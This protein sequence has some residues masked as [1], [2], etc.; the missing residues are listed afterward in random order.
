MYQFA[1]LTRWRMPGVFSC[2]R[3]LWIKPM[4]MFIDRFLSERYFISLGCVS[5]SEITVLYCKVYIREC[6]T[7]FQSGC[8]IFSS[9]R[10][11]MN[12]PLLC[13]L[14]SSCCSLGCCLVGWLVLLV[15]FCFF[16]HS[17]LLAILISLCY[18]FHLQFSNN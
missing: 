7:L 13:I 17:Y 6:Q 1:N 16:N 3:D 11:C 5:G 18:F 15:F 10:Q 2:L 4:S 12:C 8:T 9:H 14:T